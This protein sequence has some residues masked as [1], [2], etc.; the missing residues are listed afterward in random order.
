MG[1]C[2][3]IARV[4]FG[5]VC[6][7]VSNKNCRKCL[8]DWGDARERKSVFEIEHNVLARTWT[9]QISLN[10]SLSSSSICMSQTLSNILC[11]WISPQSSSSPRLAHPNNQ[12]INVFSQPNVERVELF[13]QFRIRHFP[14]IYC[15]R[16]QGLSE[17]AHN[18]MGDAASGAVSTANV[19][20]AILWATIKLT[21]NRI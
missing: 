12:A 18:R 17:I 4:A 3:P 8:A 14:G 6:G 16:D 9:K 5:C 2:I 19:Y 13:D 20:M 10:P 21:I 15:S 7:R 1:F 11:F